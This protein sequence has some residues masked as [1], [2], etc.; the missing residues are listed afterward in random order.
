L[1]AALLGAGVVNAPAIDSAAAGLGQQVST[2]PLGQLVGF[3]SPHVRCNARGLALLNEDKILSGPSEFDEGVHG[4]VSP[5]A[6]RVVSGQIDNPIWYVVSTQ[7]G[8]ISEGSC[9]GTPAEDVLVGM[10][11][12]TGTELHAYGPIK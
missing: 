8:G 12:D 10:N 4:W 9:G 2:S 7:V 3:P 6:L 11:P 1:L 5:A